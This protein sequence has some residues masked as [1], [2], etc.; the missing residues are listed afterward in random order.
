[1]KKSSNTFNQHVGNGNW[2]VVDNYVDRHPDTTRLQIE[3]ARFG[4][5]R[6]MN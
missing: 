4:S 5:R 3:T 6:H 2:K 1:M